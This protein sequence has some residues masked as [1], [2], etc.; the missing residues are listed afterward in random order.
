MQCAVNIMCMRFEDVLTIKFSV[1]HNEQE[2]KKKKMADLR[3]CEAGAP[4][5][6]LSFN[7]EIISSKYIYI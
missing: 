5:G 4:L 6:P 2:K 3:T 1:P 7:P